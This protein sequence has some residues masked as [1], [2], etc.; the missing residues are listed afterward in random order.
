VWRA[1]IESRL[2]DQPVPQRAE[3]NRREAATAIFAGFPP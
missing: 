3:E 2:R 1:V